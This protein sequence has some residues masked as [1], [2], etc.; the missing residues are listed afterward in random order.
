[1]LAY[2]RVDGVGEKRK[3]APMGG[4]VVEKKH[5]VEARKQGSEEER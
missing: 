3:G 2:F 5:E 1:M 4:M